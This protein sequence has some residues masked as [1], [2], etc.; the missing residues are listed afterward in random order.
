M[1][2]MKRRKK[3]RRKIGWVGVKTGGGGRGTPFK[4]PSLINIS[5]TAL[6]CWSVSCC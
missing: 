4:I 2:R 6:Q 5:S 1:K 3:R